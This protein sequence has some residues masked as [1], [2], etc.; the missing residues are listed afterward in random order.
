MGHSVTSMRSG[1]LA[2]VFLAVVAVPARSQRTTTDHLDVISSVTNEVVT[3]GS[4]FSIVLDIRPREGVHVYAPGATGYKIVAFNLAA[5]SLLVSRP[6]V[7]PASEIYFFEPLNERVPVYQKPF[8][9]TRNLAISTAPEHRAAVSRLK[10]MTI[11]G[12]LDYQACDD[13][14]CFTPTSIPVSVDVV[15]RPPHTERTR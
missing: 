8:R 14:A 15:V 5:N 11:R 4:R 3:P 7:Y 10:T 13:R 12:T 6:T 1:V 9:L 2:V